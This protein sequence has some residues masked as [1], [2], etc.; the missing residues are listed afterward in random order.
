MRFQNYH[1]VN[2]DG[3]VLLYTT[4]HG[5]AQPQSSVDIPFP[6]SNNMSSGQFDSI[7][8]EYLSSFSI[9]FRKRIVWSF[10]AG[11]MSFGHPPWTQRLEGKKSKPTLCMVHP[12]ADE[13]CTDCVDLWRG[14]WGYQSMIYQ[15]CSKST[16]FNQLE[17]SKSN[18][19][20]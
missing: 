4:L 18:C 2:L 9:F 6:S 20:H 15:N 7:M 14:G 19:N 16:H 1:L 5:D 12:L 13:I 10:S 11:L 8:R 17:T 3:I